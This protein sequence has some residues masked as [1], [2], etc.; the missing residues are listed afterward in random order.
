MCNNLLKLTK[1]YFKSTLSGYVTQQGGIHT[2]LLGEPY[3][4][5]LNN[6]ERK[7]C[8]HPQLLT[9][10]DDQFGRIML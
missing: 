1:S 3:A 2:F 6:V 9:P 5:K 10:D 8:P 4:K 7:Q